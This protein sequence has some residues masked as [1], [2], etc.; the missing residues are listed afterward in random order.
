MT[1][2]DEGLFAH[3]DGLSGLG[4]PLSLQEKLSVVHAHLRAA[5]PFLD[6]VAVA[7]LDDRARLLKTFVASAG[8]RPNPLRHYEVG[9][10]EAPALCEALD[11]EGP[12]VVNDLALFD[13]G[14]HVH[15]RRIRDEGFRAS[16]TLPVRAR[17]RVL[18]ALFLNSR[19]P[20]C[21]T[22]EVLDRL[23]VYAHLLA[24]IVSASILQ[25]RT[26]LAS[27]RTACRVVHFHDPE[28]GNHLERMSRYARLVARE[29]AA[30]G[31]SGLDD[32]A[33]ERIFLFAPMHDVG[34][35][36][37]PDLV[38]MKPGPLTDEE[39][40]IM[41]THT[42]RGR[43]I[44]DELIDDF[45][46]EA[47]EGLDTLRAIVECHHEMLD[48]AG[49]PRGLDGDAIPLEARIIAV[50]DVFDA[51]TSRRA[52]KEAWAN[53]RAFETLRRLAGVRLDA[54]CV[55]A[56]ERCLSEVEVLQATFRD[57]DGD[58]FANLSRS[59]AAGAGIINQT[60]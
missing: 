56:L 9:L 6:R 25:V 58:Q 47:L 31:R 32:E 39:T 45:D 13:A 17:G 18:G 33:V 48:G 49:Y 8:G 16:Y 1:T 4:R 24:E 50:A 37:I 29:L 19:V 27:M 34:K 15:T 60:S 26:L 23:D 43:E 55:A 20:D 59:R 54:D 28:T 3:G 21:F 57:G 44:I 53:E 2:T 14:L 22:P 10:E 46:L 38:L 51:L 52:Y 41:R 7:L 35:I 12:R 30:S 36:A 5:F 11:R 42:T 40:A